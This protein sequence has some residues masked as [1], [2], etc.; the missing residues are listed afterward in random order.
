M[1]W[2]G[3]NYGAAIK[4]SEHREDCVSETKKNVHSLPLKEDK[5]TNKIQ[6]SNISDFV[7]TSDPLLSSTFVAIHFC[8]P[9]IHPLSVK[10]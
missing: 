7:V 10:P 2:W 8:Q 3:M 5:R 1:R 9:H 4:S 6:V